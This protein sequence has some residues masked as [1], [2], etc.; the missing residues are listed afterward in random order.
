VSAATVTFDTKDVERT[1]K[2]LNKAGKSPQKAVT[3]AASKAITPVNRAIKYGAVPV[4]ETGN[5]K[6]AITRKAEKSRRRGKKA[7]EVTFDAKYNAVLQKP[8]KN[9]GEA[10]GKNDHAYYPASQEYGFLTRSKGGGYS[11]VPG[12]HFM[13]EGAEN[14]EPQAKTIMVDTLEKELDKLWKEATH[15]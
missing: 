3:K 12:L 1:I 8:I 11:Y 10:G 9:P 7:Y 15:A 4:G 6:R 13:R 14:A 2:M 5:L